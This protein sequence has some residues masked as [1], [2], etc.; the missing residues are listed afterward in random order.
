MTASILIEIGLEELP[1]RFI[2]ASEKQLADKMH[3]WLHASRISFNAIESYSTPRRLAV[4]V[5]DVATEQETIEEES[6]GPA[7]KIAKDSEGNWTKA[8]IGFTKGQGKTTDDIYVKEI[9]GVEYIHINKRIE[10]KRTIELLPDF[11]QEITSMHFP[12]NM[13]WGNGQMKFIRPIR[14][15]TALYGE[16]VIPFQI[17]G[18]QSS[19]ITHGHRFLGADTQ[20]HTADAY[21]ETLKSQFVIVQSN[22]REK[23]IRNQMKELEQQR[24]FT[25]AIDESLMREVRNLVEY[26]SLF[27]GNFDENYLNLPEEV[28]ITSMKEHQRYFPVKSA[29]GSLLPFFAAVRNGDKHAMD[30]VARGN[31]KVLHARL[32]DAQFFYDE[33]RKQSIATFQDKLSRV[34]FQEKLGTYQQKVNRVVQIASEIANQLNLSNDEKQ[35]TKRAAELCKFDLVTNMVNE[36]PELQGLMGMKYA[37]HFG[38]DKD[39]AI[40]IGEQYLPN[41]ANGDLPKTVAGSIVSVADKLDTIAGCIF[42]GLRP[43]GSQDPHGLRRQAIGILRIMQEH[44]WDITVEKLIHIPVDVYQSLDNMDTNVPTIEEL[45]DFVRQRAAFLLKEIS[46]QPDVIEAILSNEIGVLTYSVNK[47]KEL[48]RQRNNIEF[49]NI[50]EALVRIL[51]L[52]KKAESTSIQPELFETPSES[53]LHDKIM[54]ITNSYQAAKENQNAT[55]ALEQLSALANPI[56]EFFDHNMVMVDDE[57]LRENRLALIKYIA[58]LIIDYADFGSVEWKQHQR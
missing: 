14:W 50:Q 26:P 42:A 9:K 34:V 57:K 44:D 8:A 45:K 13:R 17:A 25:I 52:A 29:D 1:A 35:I 4:L 6:K 38:E 18:V 21:V 7:L 33:D 46:V 39:T 36:F 16:Q 20:I 51:N 15:I 27:V 31:E 12:K 56:H 28:L 3:N 47:A 58:E 40:A 10:G 5:K 37:I 53:A 43:T 48:M 49:K 11:Q 55:E 24:H 41:H 22:V 30:T 54:E 23:M 19:N 2:D 32:A